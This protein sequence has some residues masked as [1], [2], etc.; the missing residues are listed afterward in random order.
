MV[1]GIGPVAAASL[2]LAASLGGGAN[3]ANAALQS[4][5]GAAGALGASA[6]VPAATLML[7][8]VSPALAS[9]LAS[10]G[11]SAAIAKARAALSRVPVTSVPKIKALVSAELAAALSARGTGNTPQ[12]TR[13]ANVVALN[14]NLSSELARVVV[15]VC[16]L[17]R[18]FFGVALS[19]DAVLRALSGAGANVVT[20]APPTHT[21]DTWT[22]GGSFPWRNVNLWALSQAEI[23]ALERAIGAYGTTLSVAA[24][25]VVDA[26]LKSGAAWQ[27]LSHAQAASKATG[28]PTTLS[29]S[30]LK[31][32]HDH[33]RRA[34]SLANP[35]PVRPRVGRAAGAALRPKSP[36]EKARAFVRAH[37][38]IARSP[39]WTTRPVCTWSKKAT[40]SGRSRKS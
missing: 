37:A 11:A 40:A 22:L 7:G 35:S 8:N 24:Q 10:T 26:E 3:V 15:G 14:A 21:K 9:S 25:A 34:V 36:S 39:A 32:A 5:V 20:A 29:G 16:E 12:A 28:T 27:A 2:N 18:Q 4:A 31:A 30:A 19:T 38:Q 13:L 33:V 6:A 23:G 17:H 1:P